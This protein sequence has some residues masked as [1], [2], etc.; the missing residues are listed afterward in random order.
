MKRCRD[1]RHFGLEGISSDE[2]EEGP[3]SDRGFILKS[4][5]R[6]ALECA[7]D[8][9]P[10]QVPGARPTT[11]VSSRPRPEYIRTERERLPDCVVGVEQEICSGLRSRNFI[12][13]SR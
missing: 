9:V 12:T 7:F 11:M 13:L 3:G 2:A 5:D 10:P 8:L 4:S 1:R 6:T